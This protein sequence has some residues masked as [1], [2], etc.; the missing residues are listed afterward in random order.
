[1]FSQ[2]NLCHPCADVAFGVFARDLGA[3]VVEVRPVLHVLC[4]A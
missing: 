1:M 4:P 3:K 2:A